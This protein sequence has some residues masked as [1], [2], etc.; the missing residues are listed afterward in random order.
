[1]VSKATGE[2]R[3]CGD[4]R[5][6]NAQTT[7]DRYPLPKSDQYRYCLTIIDRYTRWTEA[8][9]IEDMHANKVAS[10][11]IGSRISRFGVPAR[12]TTDQGRQFESRLFHELSRL[13]GID[14]LRTTACHTQENGII[15][16]WHRT[17]KA[18]IM[19]KNRVNWPQKLPLILLRL[20]SAFKPDIQTTSA[21]L[22]YGATLENFFIK[23]PISSP[24]H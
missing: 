13:L 4:Y 22:V 15:E 20:R 1:M 2:W 23:S 5:A 24:M 14:H 18:A 9:A 19:C 17:V 3:P 16:R 21:Q 6:L 10:A 11:L 7:P 12:I 8:I